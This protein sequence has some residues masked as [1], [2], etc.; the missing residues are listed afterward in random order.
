MW[1]GR[2]IRD[3][4]PLGHIPSLVEL[5]LG[6][7][8]RYNNLDFLYQ[9]PNLTTLWLH[10]LQA[11][12][13]YSPLS[14]LRG[15]QVL[16]LEGFEK[17]RSMQIL[18]NLEKL[19]R[20]EILGTVPPGGTQGIVRYLSHLTGL[21]LMACNWVND[22]PWIDNLSR[23]K[24]LGLDCKDVRDL[25]PL[26]SLSD[27]EELDLDCPMVEDLS[28]LAELPGLK[29]LYLRRR[30]A[31]LDLTPLRD[32]AMTVYLNDA[33]TYQ[34]HRGKLGKRLRLHKLN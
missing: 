24:D 8:Q 19:T 18:G 21:R 22:L 14:T 28:P 30:M 20:L 12:E 2:A 13:D 9:V 17:L 4:S 25:R 5:S 7:A 23:L 29:T 26:T 15:L 27:L 10:K 34:K 6:N 3:L 31:N 16:R 11:V 32:R 33:N 1:S